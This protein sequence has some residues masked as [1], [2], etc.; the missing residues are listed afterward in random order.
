MAKQK[1]PA[2]TIRP[3][4]P[5]L[6]PAA[7]ARRRILSPS[8][9]G[10]VNSEPPLLSAVARPSRHS[11]GLIRE[12]GELTVNLATAAQVEAVDGCAPERPGYR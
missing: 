6:T 3:R 10:V 4:S 2:H 5:A 8:P 11:H 7:T 1:Q 9:R 12:T